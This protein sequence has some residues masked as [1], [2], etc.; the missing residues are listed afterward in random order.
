MVSEIDLFQSLREKLGETEARDL[1]AFMRATRREIEEDVRLDKSVFA[2]KED[3]ASLRAAT[4]EDIAREIASLRAATKQD[5]TELRSATKEDI[6]N[7]RTEVEKGF[8]EQL[9][10]LIVLLFGFASLI[11]TVIKFL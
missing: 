2:T 11:I 6:A 1:I 3:V 4:K 7:L 9:K 5:I 10:W 8:K